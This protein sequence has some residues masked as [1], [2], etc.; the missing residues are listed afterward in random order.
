MIIR[1]YNAFFESILPKKESPY[2]FSDGFSSILTALSDDKVAQ[3]LKWVSDNTSVLSDITL[4]D[5]SGEDKVS[6]IQVN[7]LNRMREEDTDKEQ[8]LD[9]WIRVKWANSKGSLDFRG[10][11]EQRTEMSIGRFA[12]RAL[13]GAKKIISISSS[14]IEKFVNEYKSRVKFL[15]DIDSKFELVSGEDIRKWY[16]ESSYQMSK[17]TLSNSCMRYSKCQK[18]LDIYVKNTEVCQLLV[19]HGMDNDKIT[20]RAL[21]W[22]TTSRGTYMDRPYT[23]LDSDISVFKSYARKNGWL[24]HGDVR[25]LLE[26]KLNGIEEEY[27]PYMDTFALFNYKKF[28]LSNDDGVWPNP[29]WYELRQT[30]GTYLKGDLVYSDYHDEY[31]PRDEAVHCV[32]ADGWVRDSSAI[33]LTYRSQYVT[34]DC[35]DI[36]FSSFDSESYW[37]DDTVYCEYLEDYLYSKKAT[38]AYI[39]KEES[40]YYPNEFITTGKIATFNIKGEKL[41]CFTDSIMPNPFIDGEYIFKKDPIYIYYCESID[42]YI[43]KEDAKNRDLIIDS[44]KSKKTNNIDYIKSQLGDIEYA[45]VKLFNYLKDTPLD[46]EIVEKIKKGNDAYYISQLDVSDEELFSIIKLS[47]YFSYKESEK[48]SNFKISYGKSNIRGS[49]FLA[50]NRDTFLMDIDSYTYEKLTRSSIFSRLVVD[51]IPY[52]FDIIRDNEM[53]KVYMSIKFDAI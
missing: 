46:D 20:G 33:Y 25:N 10:W 47:V 40:E 21:V 49:K 1:S 17:G 14:D 41:F 37:S 23:N 19:L 36:V 12:T 38:E 18:Y 29:D 35:D 6:F 50:D 45:K 16:L 39:N 30:D 28:I 4:V 42:S 31:I 43:T 34:S 26:V 53:R 13:S 9:H 44:D 52:I 48:T 11:K 24:T 15:N 3:S 2:F 27:Y 7:R 22:K 5:I 8:S 32:D 51:I